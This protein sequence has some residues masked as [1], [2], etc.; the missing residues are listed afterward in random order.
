MIN[1][2]VICNF[3]AMAEGDLY[4]LGVPKIQRVQRFYSVINL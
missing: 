4:K 3:W 1:N 2:V